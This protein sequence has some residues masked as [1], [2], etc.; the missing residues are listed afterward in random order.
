MSTLAK[1]RYLICKYICE[2][3]S[4]TDVEEIKGCIMGGCSSV[5]N[6]EY[7]FAIRTLIDD[8]ILNSYHTRKTYLDIDES[9]ESA[10]DLLKRLAK[11]AGL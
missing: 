8:G 1:C 11:E 5:T 2:S 7:R 3:K 10:E 6:E 9:L 4:L